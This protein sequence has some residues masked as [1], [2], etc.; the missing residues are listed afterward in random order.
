MQIA[1]MILI[2]SLLL[3]IFELILIMKT[4]INPNDIT[5]KFFDITSLH[6]K[7]QSLSNE[8][9]S[10]IKNIC[11]KGQ[12]IF[13]I[14]CGT[15]RHLIPLLDEGF[16]LTGIDSSKGML[17]ILRKKI[18]GD[19]KIIEGDILKYKFSKNEKFDL[20]ILFWNTFN[21]ICLTKTMALK[22]LNRCKILLKAEGKILINSDNSNIIN[23]ADF[24]FCTKDEIDG[25]EIV[26]TWK[27][28]SF[29][30][31][32]NT[33]FSKETVCLIDKDNSQKVFETIIKQ[34]WWTLNQYKGLA[35]EIGAS[36]KELEIKQNS[37][38]YLLL[39]PITKITQSIK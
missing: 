16:D 12:K 39:T 19:V 38:L 29:S 36:I 6:F 10:L 8:E 3:T 17:N 28:K 27:A 1:L 20:I 32:T 37:E 23:P 15:G 21:E 11:K 13:D 24:D 35:K 5:A 25:K 31:R 22:L 34:R 7:G 2:I 9:L 33:T 30:K 4:P 14:G 18:S 26:L